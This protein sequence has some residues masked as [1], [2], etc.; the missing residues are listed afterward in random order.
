MAIAEERVATLEMRVDRLETWAG[1]GQADALAI[2]MRAV[3]ADLASMRRVQ[4]QHTAMLEG[5]TADVTGLKTDVAALKTDVAAL[6]TDV[7][8]MKV[9]LQEIMRR[10]PPARQAEQLTASPGA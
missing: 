8:E 6:K 4:N 2:G 5:L 9:T 7:A 10:L 3:R 1:P